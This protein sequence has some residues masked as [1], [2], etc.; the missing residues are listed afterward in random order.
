MS[1]LAQILTL[2]AIVGISSTLELDLDLDL[3]SIYQNAEEKIEAKL[4]TIKYD[5]KA[6]SYHSR[7]KGNH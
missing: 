3:R 7:R 1:H 4:A 5:R 2:L 6:P